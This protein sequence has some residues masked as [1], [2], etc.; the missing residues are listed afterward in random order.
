M[1]KFVV[2]VFPDQQKAEQGKK[3]LDRLNDEGSLDLYAAALVGK[4]AEGN[5][6]ERERKG[7]GPRGMVLGALVGG[8]VGLLGGPPVA[9]VG[10]AGGAVMGGWRDAM[11]LGAGFDFL[12]EV[13]RELKADRWAVIAELD[14]EFASPLDARMD[15][16]G[17]I[18]L[19]S[20]REEFEDGRIRA[21]IETRRSEL[22]RWRSESE[23]AS[24]E[25]AIRI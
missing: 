9:A 7:K 20:W 16:I 15:A 18:V 5:I 4:D 8:L 14:E 19:R 21:E 10:A 22:A 1:S 23:R 12:D 6:V 2:I 11:D 24:Q 17:G 13:S 3:I 25:S